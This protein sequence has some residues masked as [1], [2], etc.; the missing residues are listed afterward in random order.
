MLSRRNV[1][2]K[3][4]Q[5]LYA[6]GKSQGT[7]PQ[8]AIQHYRNSIENTYKLFLLTLL[9]IAKVC[10][11]TQFDAST[12]SAKLLKTDEDEQFSTKLLNNPLTQ[13]LI[14]NDEF[15]TFVKNYQVTRY[16]DKDITHKIYYEFI[17]TDDFKAYQA[18]D[19]TQSNEPHCDIL[20]ALFKFLIKNNLFE[21]LAED[22]CATWAEDKTLVVGAVKK[23]IKSL[24]T[25]KDFCSRYLPDVPTSKELG[26]ELLYK[27]V[28]FERDHF[29]IIRPVLKNW[30]IERIAHIDLILIRMAITEF[31]HFPSIP[32]K[33]TLDEYIEL[34]KLY[35]TVKSSEFI[36]GVLE[37][38]KEYLLDTNQINKLTDDTETDDDGR[39]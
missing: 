36:N 9:Q 25:T 3:V 37:R 34:S 4:M 39:L 16:I 6:V 27:T 28:H 5:E 13:N 19:T 18:A 38:V 14:N 1:R 26:E 24:H 23:V 29:G 8:Q 15:K 35:S 11:Y 10:E 21:E 31:L 7:T 17:K 33:A 20:L 30:D 32:V 2:V 22:C 12:R